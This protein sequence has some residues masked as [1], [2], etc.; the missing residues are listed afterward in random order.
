MLEIW[1]VFGLI[2]REMGEY[3]GQLRGEWLRLWVFLPGKAGGDGLA[4]HDGG[5]RRIELGLV[6]MVWLLS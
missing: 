4:G 1:L 2:E 3:Y 5:G 6:E